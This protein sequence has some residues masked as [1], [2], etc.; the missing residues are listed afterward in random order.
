MDTWISYFAITCDLAW[1]PAPLPVKE[2]LMCGRAGITH[3]KTRKQGVGE[4]R[5]KSWFALVSTCSYK[6][7]HQ[8]TSFCFYSDHG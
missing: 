7:A 1:L 5:F 3:L 8:G 2:V 6:K 4:L